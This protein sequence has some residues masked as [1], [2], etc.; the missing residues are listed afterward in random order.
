MTII[1]SNC[2]HNSAVSSSSRLITKIK[3]LSVLGLMVQSSNFVLKSING[4]Q[5]SFFASNMS[6]GFK[7]FHK[8][9]TIIQPPSTEKKRICGPM[10]LRGIELI[11][12]FGSIVKNIDEQKLIQN[13]NV[14]EDMKSMSSGTNPKNESKILPTSKVVSAPASKSYILSEILEASKVS[15]LFY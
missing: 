11:M 1:K 6:N 14:L 8:P 3:P 9:L 5:K 4:L 10:E 12:K 2:L 7:Q 13:Q 15:N